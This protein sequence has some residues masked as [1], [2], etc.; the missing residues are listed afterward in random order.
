LNPKVSIII[1]SFNRADMILTAIESAQAQTFT[2]WE[3]IIVDDGS[4]DNTREVVAGVKDARVR[5]IFQENKGLPGARN[6]GIR[7]S[8]ADY[9]AFLDSDDAFLPQKLALQVP[10]MDENPGLGL[11]AGGYIEVDPNMKFLHEQCPWEKHPTLELPDWVQTCMFCVG[12]PLVRRAWLDKAGLFDESMRFVEDWDLW[13]RMSFLGCR[14]QWLEE[15]VYLYRIHGSNMVR[16]AVRMKNGMIAMFDKFFAQPNLPDQVTGLRDGAYGHVYLNAA[17][18]AL[19]S[20]DGDEG[21]VCLKAAFEYDPSL[22]DGQP[23]RAIDTLASFALTPLCPDKHK[24]MELLARSLP[25]P[26]VG[27]PRRRIY[28]ALYAVEAFEKAALG[29]AG[30]AGSTLKAIWN[31]PTWLRNRGLMVLALRSLGSLRQKN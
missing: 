19:A 8:R 25:E 26:L 4:T 21:R 27:W 30:V 7:A 14:M 23:P 18:R 16:Q 2:E 9:L 20:E 12:S 11:V 29:Q 28:G 31:D 5:Y 17:A 13:L 6:A 3:A 15:P 22:L 1:P 24:F 10:I